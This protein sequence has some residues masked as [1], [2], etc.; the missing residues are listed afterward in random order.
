MRERSVIRV[1][2]LRSACRGDIAG[3]GC[4]KGD[5]R[6]WRELAPGLAGRREP[7]GWAF[8]RLSAK[9]GRQEREDS[10]QR[11]D[12]EHQEKKGRGGRAEEALGRG[13]GG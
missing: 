2:C 5:A 9:L 1:A 13:R 6:G 10:G 12:A 3:A 7:L 4:G 11:G 8:L